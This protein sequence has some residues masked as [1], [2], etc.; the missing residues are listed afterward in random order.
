MRDGFIK[1]LGISEKFSG[2]FLNRQ[3]FITPGAVSYKPSPGTKRIKIILTGGGG[4]GYG[5]LGWA[6]DFIRVAQAVGQA[7]LQSP[8]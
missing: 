3:I 4:R 5:Y 2:R 7:G 8:G 1:N 6:M